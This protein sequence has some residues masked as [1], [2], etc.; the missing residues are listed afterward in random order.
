VATVYLSE[1]DKQY[2]EGIKNRWHRKYENIKFRG[3]QTISCP[4]W[5]REYE[6]RADK[7]GYEWRETITR[8]QIACPVLEGLDPTDLPYQ[9]F[10]YDEESRLIP[11]R[12]RN[13]YS[14]SGS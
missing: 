13:Y 6:Q 2:G 11:V 7:S 14:S 8:I 12:S 3:W 10:R 5:Y 1:P 4:V 9:F